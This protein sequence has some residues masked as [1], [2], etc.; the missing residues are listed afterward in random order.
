MHD[1]EHIIPM[2]TADFRHWLVLLVLASILCELGFLYM[3]TLMW[4]K[5]AWFGYTPD[6][7]GM[8]VPPLFVWMAY[9]RLK[10]PSSPSAG[11]PVLGSLILFF[12]LAALILARVIDIRFAQAMSFI[13]VAFGLVIIFGGV[14]FSGKFLF[15]FVFLAL[16]I[17]SVSYLIESLAGAVLRK[18]VLLCSYAVLKA[19]GGSWQLNA[20]G[21]QYGSEFLQVGFSRNG[22]SS[23]LFLLIVHFAAAELA[24]KNEMQRFFFMVHF[25]LYF[26]AAYI[27][28]Y[29]LAGWTMMLGNN[30]LGAMFASAQQWIPLLCFI[31]MMIAVIFFA[32]R[33][34]RKKGQ[35]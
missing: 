14:R 32:R 30:T 20:A 29:T 23:I 9:T 28:Y 6:R 10:R 31:A 12:S 24:F 1:K 35:L 5:T 15:P 4:M 18:A 16:M 19:F 26:I 25:L 7:A 22:F 27:C 17:P 2:Q 8:F 3:D 34:D 13:G 33:F 11:A 21:L